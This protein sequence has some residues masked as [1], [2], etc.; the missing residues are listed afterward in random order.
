M[1][2]AMMSLSVLLEIEEDQFP[3]EVLTPTC[4]AI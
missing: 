3:D 4:C 1:T 2:D